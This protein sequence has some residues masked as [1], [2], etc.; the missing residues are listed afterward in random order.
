MT[1][2]SRMSRRSLLA[3]G[4]GASALL[5]AGQAEA[6]GLAV[7]LDMSRIAASGGDHP[8]LRA[9][10]QQEYGRAFAGSYSGAGQTVLVRVKSVYFSSGGGGRGRGGAR[11]DAGGDTDYLDADVQLIGARG[12]VLASYS[13]LS[14][15]PVGGSGA[16]I[17]SPEQDR[18]RLTALARHNAGWARRYILG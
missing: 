10:L 7:R 2:A 17:W 16:M 3:T 9:V 18:L 14:P 8:L 5:L 11:G 1:A 6:A 15:V 12:Q 13:I 4:L